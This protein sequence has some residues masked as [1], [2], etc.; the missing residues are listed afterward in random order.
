MAIKFKCR[1]LI[2][3]FIPKSSNVC[4]RLYINRFHFNPNL[5]GLCRGFVLRQAGG[6]GGVGLWGGKI[7]SLS[8]TC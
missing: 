5:G 3:I 2:I 4:A 8:K 1:V 6:G 7:T